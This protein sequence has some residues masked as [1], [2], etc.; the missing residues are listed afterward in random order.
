MQTRQ[1]EVHLT[2]I[3]NT[4]IAD[5]DL[6]PLKEG[7]ITVAIDRFA[8]TA[9]NITYAVVGERIG[10]WN[11]FP[12]DDPE[13]GLVP[14]WGF[15]NVIESSHDDIAVGERLYGYWPMGTHL[16]M[17]PGRVSAQ[18]F[19]DTTSHRAELPPVYNAYARC[20]HEAH[21]DANLD[22]ARM[23]LF[24]LYATSFC[25]YDFLIANEFFGAEQIIIPSASS[26]TSVGLAFGLAGD[27]G[28]RAVV[29][30]TSPGNIQTVENMGFYNAVFS[31]DDLESVDATV[32]TVI[33]DM[34][35]N[36]EVL[37]KLHERLGDNMRYT[38]NVGLTHYQD[39][40]MGEHFIRAR[41]AM[42]FAPGHMQQR[43][44]EWGPGEFEK[45]SYQFWLDA[46]TATAA[47]L[48][49]RHLSGSELM[50]AAYR[51]VL[52]GEAKP[53]VGLIISPSE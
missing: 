42:F 7:E 14:V 47:W 12:V 21:Y 37:S 30:L 8:L 51:E 29:G 23:L 40:Q 50:Q 36:G 49:Y 1:L 53:D 18:R 33:V 52:S 22:D 19:F 45:R 11:F 9:N 35:G 27:S 5:V 46:T 24:P 32:P 44:K 31:Y 48:K 10:Y 43:N 4:R 38:S 34:S 26:K 2:Q 20:S 15:A 6:P 28:K 17:Q 16:R 3:A 13:Y 39:N 25:L 41:S